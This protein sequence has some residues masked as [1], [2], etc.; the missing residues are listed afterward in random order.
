MR[1]SIPSA[2]FRPSSVT[3]PRTRLS[4]LN[5]LALWRSRRALGALCENQ[6][7]DIGISRSQARAEAAK[8]IWDAPSSWRC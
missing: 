5:L 8:P 6:L 4:L 1:I 3:R 2:F 7:Q